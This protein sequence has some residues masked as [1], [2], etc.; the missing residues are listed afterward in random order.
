MWIKNITY[1]FIFI[2]TLGGYGKSI[3]QIKDNAVE[4]TNP[5]TSKYEG[6]QISRTDL[7]E[8]LSTVDPVLH[9]KETP[10]TKGLPQFTAIG[11]NATHV[12]ITGSEN[13]VIRAVWLINY[14]VTQ[15]INK[16][17][18][19]RMAFFVNTLT[20]QEGATWL[21]QQVFAVNNAPTSIL[22]TV[23]TINGSRLLFFYDPSKKS[24]LVT[25]S[26]A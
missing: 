6:F 24:I 2:L 17:V 22:N 14:D 10:K 19:N 15:A 3:G 8:A 4:K 13:N 12:E 1:L 21:F 9:F 20:K 25:V 7:F 11:A 18:I 23:T 5:L 16:D 26:I